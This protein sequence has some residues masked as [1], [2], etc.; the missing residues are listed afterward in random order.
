[1]DLSKVY[2]IGAEFKDLNSTRS[3]QHF[4]AEVILIDRS[5]PEAKPTL[6]QLTP[7]PNLQED[8]KAIKQGIITLSEDA[9][10]TVGEVKQI[11]K[12]TK[13]IILT[14]GNTVTYKYLILANRNPNTSLKQDEFLSSLNTLFYALLLSKTLPTINTNLE[15]KDKNSTFAYTDTVKTQKSIEKIVNTNLANDDICPSTSSHTP[16]QKICEIQV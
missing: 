11:N 1:M 2:I 14:N 9:F 4:Y 16:H 15:A 3:T 6:Y 10:V 8:L 12:A 5:L 13:T 7:E